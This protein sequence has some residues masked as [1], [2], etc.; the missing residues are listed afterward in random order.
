MTKEKF[1]EKAK[2]IHGDRYDYSKVEYSNN[3][4]KVCIICPVHGEFW[5]T[6]HTHLQGCGCP[7]CYG[8]KKRT[9]EEFV[10]EARKIHGDRYD[11][12]RVEYIN[13]K[14][15]VCIICPEHGEFWQ[16]P[17]NHLVAKQGCP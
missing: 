13:N 8:T 12:S 2:A 4:T 11:Y 16:K 5:Q 9:K 7:A 17:E 1:I 14:T 10:E 6:P 15:P 3:R